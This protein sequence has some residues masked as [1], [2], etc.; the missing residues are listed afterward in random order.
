MPIIRHIPETIWRTGTVRLT[1]VQAHPY[2][3]CL[4]AVDRQGA[5]TYTIA[6]D[7]HCVLCLE[8]RRDA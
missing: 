7:P 4:Y 3:R 2:H 6:Y 1:L 8:E 5:G